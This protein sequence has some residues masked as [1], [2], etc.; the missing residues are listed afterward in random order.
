MKLYY[1]FKTAKV[2]MK[3]IWIGLKPSRSITKRKHLEPFT[4]VGTAKTSTF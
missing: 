2:N 4:L 3:I 1:S